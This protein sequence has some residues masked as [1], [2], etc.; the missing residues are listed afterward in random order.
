VA[1]EDCVHLVGT[2]ARLVDP[3]AIDGDG[4][5]G[6]RKQTVEVINMARIK[7]GFLRNGCNVP[8]LG[9]S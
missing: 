3:L 7:S 5:G 1:I 9:R 4:L 6:V 2:G 8:A